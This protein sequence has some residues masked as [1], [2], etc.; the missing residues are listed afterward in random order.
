VAARNPQ[1][2]HRLSPSAIKYITKPGWH[3][4][5]GGLYLEVDANG[6]KRWAMRLVVNGRR[7]DFG[8]GPLH[9]VGLADAREMA[10]E[11]RAKA[12]R[13]IDPVEH[14]RKKQKPVKVPTFKEAADTVYQQR[15]AGWSNGK[16]VNQWINTLIDYAFPFIGTKRVN[17]I[18]T[19]EV[20]QVL[21]PIWLTK[22]ETARRVRQ[23]LS[24]ILE[25]AR[26]AGHRSGDNPVDLI[27]DALPKQKKRERHHAALPYARVPQFIGALRAGR[28]EPITKLAFEFLIL[29]AV[30]TTDVRLALWEE[31][32]EAASTW[33]IPGYDEE[34]GRR[35]KAEREHIVPLSERCLEILK[36]AKE[37]SGGQKL[38]FPD[39]EFDRVM[40]EN[41]FLVARNGLGYTKDQCT[42]HGFR[43]SFR[44][45][46]AEETSFP[47]EVVEMALAHAI[48][49]K[50]EAA[51]RR[52]TLLA[53][54]TELMKAWAEYACAP[55]NVDSPAR[56][57]DQSDTLAA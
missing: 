48:K 4:D 30:R 49:N 55:P 50:T 41:R 46:A 9:K 39:D 12:Y 19:P 3:C 5:G 24:I 37:I 33:T 52:G 42:P 20:L 16:H 51:Y 14:K 38:V 2:I 7:R 13:G 26:V 31:F 43:S 25:W 57:C 44:D 21:S 27:G 40:S 45:W 18:G 22:P 32:D 8:L 15:R 53:K 35:T 54:R 47:A 10:A 11:Y 34:T 28:A 1:G 36:A 23:R 29:T 6:R 17:E 56:D